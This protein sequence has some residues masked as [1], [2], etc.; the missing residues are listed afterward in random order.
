[1]NTPYFSIIIPTLNEE[2]ALPNLLSDLEHQSYQE[3]EL[4]IV[5]GG[6]SD[7]TQSIVKDFQKSNSNTTLLTSTKQNVSH[8][9]NLGAKKAN[10]RYLIFL[11]ADTRIPHYFLE[12][13]HYQLIKEPADLWMYHTAP[14]FDESE[15]E[16]PHQV[17]N[18]RHDILAILG[19]PAIMEAAMGS[20]REVFATLQGFSEEMVIA[21][22]IEIMQ[23]ASQLGYS[24]AIFQDPEFHYS[25]R[26]YNKDGAFGIVLGTLP[27][28]MRNLLGIKLNS[29][30]RFYPMSGGTYYLD[31]SRRNEKLNLS[32]EMKTQLQSIQKRIEESLKSF[33]QS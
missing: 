24:F 10:G 32:A 23:R 28:E 15:S 8:Q 26:R 31:Q 7:K 20:K 2:Q 29:K 27:N 21:E 11:D 14:L 22:G 3:F 25:L 30:S 4:F 19:K 17:L 13:T 1:M 33:M 5:D 12:G 16:L 18:L 6:S 9:R